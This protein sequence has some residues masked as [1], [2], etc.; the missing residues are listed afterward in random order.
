[1][2]I[3]EIEAA[4]PFMRFIQDAC[5]SMDPDAV[6]CFT[7][8]MEE[9]IE[10]CTHF[11]W[12][13]ERQGNSTPL[14]VHLRDAAVSPDNATTMALFFDALATAKRQSLSTI[15]DKDEAMLSLLKR[16][17]VLKTLYRVLLTE[18]VDVTPPYIAEQYN[19][20]HDSF[21]SY[22]C[23][24]VYTHQFGGTPEKLENTNKRKAPSVE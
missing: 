18:D 6:T 10:A 24:F 1:M 5:M 2:K 19:L 3:D 20:D 11:L 15:A 9:C 13:Y 7:S 16:M 23:I 4:W 17:T 8:S 12:L 21:G 14:D 22:V